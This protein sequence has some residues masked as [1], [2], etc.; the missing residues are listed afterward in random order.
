[1][2]GAIIGQKTNSWFQVKSSSPF[3]KITSSSKEVVKT[4]IGNALLKL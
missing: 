2:P 1:M 4:L 3:L